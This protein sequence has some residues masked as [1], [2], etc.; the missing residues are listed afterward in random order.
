MGYF[1][2]GS[3]ICSIFPSSGEEQTGRDIRGNVLVPPEIIDGDFWTGKNL[4]KEK[5]QI[6]ALESGIVRRGKDWLDL[7]AFQNHKWNVYLSDNKADCF[8]DVISGHK[9][10]P[11]PGLG[12]IKK[13][14]ANLSVPE[15]SL[16]SDQNII[17][18]VKS[19]CQSGGAQSFCLTRDRDGSYEIEINSLSTEAYL[20]LYKGS[21]HGSDL[22]LKEAWNA[23]LALKIDKLEIPR[24]KKEI[25]DF[26]S[27][28]ST[29]TSIFLARGEDPRRGDD[30][31]IILET[32][33]LPETEV[34]T[35]K[36]RIKD[37]TLL[38]PS[39]KDFPADE[40]DK[41]AKVKKGMKLF[42]LGQHKGGKDGRDIFGNVIKGIE[43]NDPDLNIYENI[44]M[45][46]GIASSMIDGIL[47]LSV[48]NGTYSLRVREH[49]DAR[50]VITLSDNK[51]TAYASFLSPQGSGL[52]V[53]PER[54]KSVLAEK[55]VVKGIL[56]D[57]IRKI[58]LWADEGKIVTDH[59]VA[60]GKIP[61]QGE[62]TLK[63]LIDI[64][65]GK[66][67]KVP[68][69]QGD[70]VAELKKQSEGDA[71]GYNVLGE[72]LFSGDEKGLERDSNVLQVEEDGKI[73]L[74]AGSKGLLCVE[75]G[76]IYI[77]EKMSIRGDVS[78]TG[79]N[80]NFPGS[81]AISGSVLSGI[82]VSAGK[83]LTVMEVVEASL[84]SAGGSILIGKG[85]KGEKRAVL[86]AGEN[87]SLGF[88]ENTNLMVNGVLKIGKALMNCICKCNG[89]I[90]SDGDKTRIIGG[91]I[92]VKNGLTAGSLGSESE[93]KTVVSFGQDYLVEDQIN[94]MTKEIEGIN[95]QLQEIDSQLKLAEEKRNQK[96]LMA[97]R[98]NKVQLLKILEKKGIKNFFLKEKFEVHYESMIKVYNDI[99]PGVIFESHGRTLAVREKLSSVIIYF[100]SSTG[101][102]NKKPL[103]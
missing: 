71:A 22:N 18:M 51:M 56:D 95:Q 69:N 96:K 68:V 9:A 90:V 77:K 66:K 47:D 43:G 70:I 26:N 99:H 78:R 15:S 8:I 54:I 24:V 39:F 97:L 88:A 23:V 86:R 60:E 100:D 85:V 30:R 46:D 101:K 25:L 41:M 16:I 19:G 29:E 2:E 67:D 3:V 79:G 93:V 1:E 81:V 27:S 42:H 61:F 65:P 92:K 5:S 48:R 64:E 74:K 80:I 53:S 37:L 31:E 102:I 33:Y 6:I 7:V 13:A 44:N 32:E 62:Q 52:P 28:D 21:G 91:N 10:A 57:E 14:I 94:V 83:D 45:Q 98:K 58:S 72:Q 38:A 50:I 63:F 49:E 59:P 12:E 73:L 76:H 11:P 75:D 36:K 34:D 40:I 35:I 55:G 82:F 4:K 20:H 103:T 87:I 89:K 84:L 17:Q